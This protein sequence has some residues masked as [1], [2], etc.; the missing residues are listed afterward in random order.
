[1]TKEEKWNEFYIKEG[2]VLGNLYNELID[3][4]INMR[5]DCIHTGVDPE[6]DDKWLAGYYKALGYVLDRIFDM[7][8]PYYR[9]HFMTC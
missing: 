3:D 2:K 7:R 9:E 5:K 6:K 4:R 8:E 1:M